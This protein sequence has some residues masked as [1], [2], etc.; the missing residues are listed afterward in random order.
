MEIEIIT[1]EDLQQFKSELLSE[2]KETLGTHQGQVKE[3]LDTKEVMELLGI[4]SKTTL[5][6]LRANNPR[7]LEAEGYE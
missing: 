7:Y 6:K 1:K 4:K 3:W 5:Q 2:L